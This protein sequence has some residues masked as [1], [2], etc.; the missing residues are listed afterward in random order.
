MAKDKNPQA[1][2]ARMMKLGTMTS[3]RQMSM[4]RRPLPLVIY[5]HVLKTHFY[6]YA[7]CTLALLSYFIARVTALSPRGTLSAP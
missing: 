7:A 3:T 1:C 2:Q 6:P 5:R 4:V